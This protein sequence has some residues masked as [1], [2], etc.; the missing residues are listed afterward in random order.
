MEQGNNKLD[1]AV[2]YYSSFS[3]DEDDDDD[4]VDE[5]HNGTPF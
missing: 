3:I 4:N 5:S 2:N 1:V